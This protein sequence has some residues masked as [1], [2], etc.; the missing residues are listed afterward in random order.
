MTTITVPATYFNWVVKPIKPI[1]ENPINVFVT[2]E[3][4]DKKNTTEFWELLINEVDSS[5]LREIEK[6]KNLPDSYFV[7]LK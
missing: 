1:K 2:F 4:L 6:A 7:N 5:I 3:Y